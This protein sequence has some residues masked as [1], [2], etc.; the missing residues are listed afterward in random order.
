ML[1]SKFQFIWLKQFLQRRFFRNRPIRNKNCLWWSCLLTDR[2]EICNFHRG[3]SIDA[4]YQ[5]SVYLAKGFQRRLKCKKLMDNRRQ[6]PSDGKS[7]HNLWQGELKR[8]L[9]CE[10]L[11]VMYSINMFHYI[12]IS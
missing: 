11:H 6:K 10:Y 12:S 7:S 2:D 4:S 1:P 5:V 9:K 8:I 3:H